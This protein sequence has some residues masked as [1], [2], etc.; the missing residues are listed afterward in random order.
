MNLSPFPIQPELTAIAM[1]YHNAQLIADAVLPR[2]PVGKQT[3]KY[4]TY[5]K[6][7]RFTLPDTKVG[8]KSAPN[9]VE[10]GG[11][12]TEASTEDY[13]LDDDVPQADI[14]NAAGTSINPLGN[15]VEGVSALIALDREVRVAGMV[16][17][18]ANYPAANKTTLSGTD[19]WSD[20]TNSDPIGDILDALDVPLMR[21]NIGVIGMAAFNKLR[22]HP[23]IAK[24]IHGNSGD[25][26]ITTRR[27]IADLFELEDLLVGLGRYNSAKKGQTASY[28]NIWGKHMALLYRDQAV[29]SG[30][31]NVTFGFTAQWG[32]KVAGAMDNPNIG[33]RGG[34]TVRTGESVKELIIASDVG[35]LYTNCVA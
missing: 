8:R 35:Y 7:D 24:A 17:A 6:S 19:Q 16:F 14:D 23:A 3:F 5:T 20:F 32:D 11:T 28:D 31:D 34:K 22:Q 27:Q 18:A 33:L 13:G 2:K 10:F 30:A 26:A 4:T 21:P 9:K 15:A 1:A 25:K 12:E 29:L